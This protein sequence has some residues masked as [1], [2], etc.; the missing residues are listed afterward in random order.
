MAIGPVV[1]VVAGLVSAVVPP[2]A[3]A[4]PLG[5]FAV[6]LGLF[7]AM[8]SLGCRGVR[9]GRRCRLPGRVSGPAVAR[10][11]GARRELAHR[12]DRDPGTRRV[13][14]ADQRIERGGD[15]QCLM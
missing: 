12:V 15:A 8:T 13:P 4:V 3:G 10:A 14:E 9:P 5:L 6:A 11:A 2:S 7:A 1:V